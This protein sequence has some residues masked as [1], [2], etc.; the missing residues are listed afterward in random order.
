M[1]NLAAQGLKCGIPKPLLSDFLQVLLISRYFGDFME[2]RP[3][4]TK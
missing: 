2:F 4:E 3:E 1:Q